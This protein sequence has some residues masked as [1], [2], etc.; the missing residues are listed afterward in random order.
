M[1]D[2]LSAWGSPSTVFGTEVRAAYVA[3][4]QDPIHVHAICE[5]Y[6]AA[7]TLDRLHDDTDSKTGRRIACPLLALWS[8][9]GP[10]DSWYRDEGGP[11]TLWQAWGDDVRGRALNAGH[12]F[13]EE[14][15]NET[16]DELGRFFQGIS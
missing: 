5:E 16:A 13:P 9:L 4:L 10:L 12:F 11:L 6:R 3:A 8:G 2:A 15:P 14:V 1:D 7:A